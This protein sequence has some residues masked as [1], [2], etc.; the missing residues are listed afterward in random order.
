MSE[1]WSSL[2]LRVLAVEDGVFT[3]DRRLLDKAFLVGVLMHYDAVEKIFIDIIEVDGLDATEKVLS[4]INK[5]KPLDLVL[6][7]GIPYAG[8]NLIDADEVYS[9]TGY[10]IICVLD[11]KPDMA[12]VLKALKS[13]FTD[14]CERFNILKKQGEP[15]EVVLD[16]RLVLSIYGIDLETALQTLKAITFLGKTPEPLRVARLIAKGLPPPPLV[17]VSL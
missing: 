2:R 8:F 14:W 10:P 7:H 11:R 17:E 16:G 9:L 5:S 1:R 3:I 15:V 6:L 13:K 12:N 4:F